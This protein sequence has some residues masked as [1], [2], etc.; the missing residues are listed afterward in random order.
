VTKLDGTLIE[1]IG[2]GAR[3]SADG[4]LAEATFYRPQ[5]LAL[6][7][8]KLYVADTEN[9]LIRLVDLTNRRVQTIAGTGKQSREYEARGAA[10]AVA[11]NSPWDLQLVGRTLYVAM[12]GQHQIWQLDL[13]KME[14]STFAGTGR[15]ARTDGAVSEAAFAQP[16][17]L[18]SDKRN[19]YVADSE[20]NIIRQINLKSAND[21]AANVRTLAGGDLFEF[22]DVD[23]HGDEA[24]LQHPLGLVA[25]NG[26]LFIADTYNHKIKQLDPQTGAVATF[27]GTGRPGQRDGANASFYEPGGLSIA[28]DKLYVADTNNQAI[29]VID[30]KTKQTT[31]L[32]IK[33]LQPPAFLAE[34]TEMSGESTPNVEEIKLESQ[35]L[36]ATARDSALVLNVRLPA[37]YHLNPSA[38]QRY[39]VAIETGANALA[40][41]ENTATSRQLSGKLTALPL[42]ITLR[43]LAHGAAEL[44]ITAT[45]YYCRED[46][47]GTCKL[48]TLQ[49]RTPIVITDKADALRE[50]KAEGE[51][52]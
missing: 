1:T 43:P 28:S 52:K 41:V 37:G 31:T 25:Y 3:G 9:H 38:P 42:R 7:D 45:I 21:A 15:E 11:L 8:D 18:A 2:A 27:L 16:S 49:W 44:R 6:D 23:G 50:I 33:N 32:V 26:K 34:R 14:I 39:K 40:L 24:R 29:R 4:S 48:K 30:L 51:I 46:N 17:G 5:G 47:T 19:L 20:S 12:A 35:H 36:S 22:G 10:R 13:D